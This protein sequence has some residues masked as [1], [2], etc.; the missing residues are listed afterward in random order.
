M[1][2]ESESP[3]KHHASYRQILGAYNAGKLAVKK[4]SA[5]NRL[6]GVYG[7]K[8]Q[9][10]K[11]YQK[12]PKQEKP[13]H[14][15]GKADVV[16]EKIGGFLKNKDILNLEQVSKTTKEAIRGHPDIMKR[17]FLNSKMKDLEHLV[18][19]TTDE[20]AEF[21]RMI[22]AKDKSEYAK[23]LFKFCIN[24]NE[25]YEGIK[26]DL[27]D[28]FFYI[29]FDNNPEDEDEKPYSFLWYHSY[30]KKTRLSYVDMARTLVIGVPPPVGD[31][32]EDEYYDNF[33]DMDMDD[34]VEENS[35]VYNLGNLFPKF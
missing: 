14:D 21:L 25:E 22:N 33:T 35:T 7:F 32:D 15:I 5:V 6:F 26:D 31:V 8:Q 3:K 4:G 18:F 12:K 9:K 24:R 10:Q 29:V 28:H 13:K 30:G 19:K 34:Y 1:K 2:R 27:D 16:M 11:P 17:D 20:L 23:K